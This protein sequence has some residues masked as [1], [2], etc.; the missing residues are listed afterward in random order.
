MIKVENVEK[1][2]G[3]IK[4]LNGVSLTVK[5]GSIYGLIGTN[6]SGKS[7]LL[8]T[9]AGI[10]R[11]EKGKIEID[12][13]NIYENPILKRRIVYISDDQFIIPSST[14]EDVKDFYK[15][16]YPNFDTEE[17][18]KLTD[19]FSLDRKR[20]IT[21]FSKGMKKQLDIISAV[22]SRPDYIYLD[23]TFDG[24]DPVVREEV[25]RMLAY[26]SAERGMSSVI[27]SHN[28][29]EIEDIEML[30]ERTRGEKRGVGAAAVLFEI[31]EAHSAIF[32]DGVIGLLWE[33]QVGVHNSVSFGVSEFHNSSSVI[34]YFLHSHSTIFVLKRRMCG[35]AFS[36]TLSQFATKLTGEKYFLSLRTNFAFSCR[37]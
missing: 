25:K 22:S 18:D 11:A 19:R 36:F 16:M 14:A 9:M 15:N 28:L 12:G 30:I 20:Q 34:Q 37:I 7:T 8:R 31:V 10:F 1:Y 13:E 29:R 32:A 24:L 4:A 23:E 33:S 27:A 2:Y 35:M 6:G 3:K 17:F 21:G 26:E 5:D